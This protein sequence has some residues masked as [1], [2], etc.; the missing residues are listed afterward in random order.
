MCSLLVPFLRCVQLPMLSL[1]RE[2]ERDACCEQME[3]FLR[4]VQLP[5]LS[6]LQREQERDALRTDGA[7]SRPLSQTK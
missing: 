5:M 3:Q 6:I 7:G 4:C 1:Q 2:Q